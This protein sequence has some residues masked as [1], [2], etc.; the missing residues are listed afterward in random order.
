MLSPEELAELDQRFGANADKLITRVTRKLYSFSEGSAGPKPASF[1]NCIQ[2]EMTDVVYEDDDSWPLWLDDAV[3]GVARLDWYGPREV[4]RPLST[5]KIVQCFALLETINTSTISHLLKVERRQAA[6]YFKACELLHERL[7][8]NFCDDTVRS[9][10]Y[11]AVFIYP[12]EM[13]PMT[14]I[15]EE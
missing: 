8:D 13:Q 1:V 4:Q 12:R 2:P 6:R 3:Q 15:K 14:D 10:R 11:P 5:K 9:M 7:I